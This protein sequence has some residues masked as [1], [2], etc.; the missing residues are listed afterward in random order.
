MRFSLLF[1][2][3]LHLSTTF[4]QT[5]NS[6]EVLISSQ[7]ETNLNISSK[8]SIFTD[9]TRQMSFDDV[10]SQSFIK[11]FNDYYF[12]PFSD[13]IYWIRFDLKNTDSKATDFVLVWNNPM[14][15]QLDFYI[16]DSLG[17]KIDCTVQKLYTNNK[18]KKLYAELPHYEFKLAQHS[19]KTLYIRLSN[20]RGFQ[21]TLNLFTTAAFINDRYDNFAEQ[22]I[23]IGLV[24]FRLLLV[25]ILGFFIIKEPVFKAYSFQIIL[26]TASFFGLQ[27]VFF[28]HRGQ[29]HL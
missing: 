20:K 18:L 19:S 8:M 22:G 23:I 24:I 13:D 9:K 5:V 6:Q 21:C 3:F 2:I 7:S 25:L 29:K 4:A 10:R 27:N 28:F 12:F 14:T 15:E 11:N 17:K 16:S 1:F 26:K